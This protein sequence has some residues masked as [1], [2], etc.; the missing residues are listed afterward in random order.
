MVAGSCLAND[1][2]KVKIPLIRQH[3][4]DR[5]DEEQRLMDRADGKQDS[6]F[7]AGS[8]EALVER[9]TEAL[10]GRVNKLQDWIETNPRLVSNNDKV[11]F[12]KYIENLLDHYRT[13]YKKKEISGQLFLEVFDGFEKMLYALDRHESILS[14]IC[15][16]VKSL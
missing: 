8:Q 3:F 9:S 10:F 5:I 13:A 15:G 16:G 6:S 7:H 4:H 12:L 14:C 2:V 11:R 1:T